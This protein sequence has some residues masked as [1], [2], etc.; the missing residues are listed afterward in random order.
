MNP[1]SASTASRRRLA[2][3][4]KAC[5]LALL[6][7]TAAI[8][9]MLLNGPLSTASAHPCPDVEVVFARGT[10]EPSGVGG[11]GQAFVSAL[12]TQIGAKSMGIYAVN[13]PARGD[14]TSTDF[15]KTVT[16]GI[17]DESSPVQ[18]VAADCPTTMMVLGGY[19]QGAVVTGFTTEAAIPRGAPTTGV[20]EPLPSPIADHVAAAALFGKPSEQS[21]QMYGAPPV[22]IGPRYASKTIDLCARD[23]TICNGA[24]NG[25]PTVA[26][27]L[28]TVNG[29]L[30]Q[31]A[32]FVSS[33]L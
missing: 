5:R 2:T 1:R 21:L 11:V 18:S 3:I 23:D 7:P 16:D 19:S 22:V 9:A 26:H 20:P 28:Y 10:G 24:P 15:P 8:C 30:T 25:S 27:T 4:A 13:Y 6:V 12:R 29:M 32:S 17:R 33:R 31:A 14:F